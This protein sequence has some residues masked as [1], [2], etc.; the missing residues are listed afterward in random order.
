MTDTTP[1]TTIVH[2]PPPPAEFGFA[3]DPCLTPAADLLDAVIDRLHDGRRCTPAVVATG[4]AAFDST[5]GGL[6]AGMLTVVC[7]PPGADR[8]TPLL[9][10]AVHAARQNHHV[11]VY[12]LGATVAPFS[13]RVA[14]VASGVALY[15]LEADAPTD[16]EMAALADAQRWLAGVSLE[17]MV[18][19]T[20]STHDIRAM[21][22]SADDPP[23]L[24]VIDN[25]S[26]LAHG[27]RATDLKHLA[28]DLNVAV[29]CSTTVPASCDGLEPGWPDGDLLN[30]SDTITWAGPAGR[31]TLVESA[32]RRSP[33]AHDERRLA[34]A[35]PGSARSRPAS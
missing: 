5:A 26:L 6:G 8:T 12:A 13:A 1:S 15:R 27:G 14:S 19:Q 9:A 20:V 30:A 7:A 25:F 18:G 21:C 16:A 35:E 22:L 34:E 4:I 11:V 29:L 32:S 24:I 33:V 23:E 17:F 2:L 3:P 31:V 10:A 28:V